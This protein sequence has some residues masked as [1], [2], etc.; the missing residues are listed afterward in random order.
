MEQHREAIFL[1]VE[2]IPGGGEEGAGRVG[3][4]WRGFCGDGPQRGEEGRQLCGLSK[5]TDRLHTLSTAVQGFSE[6]GACP[7]Q[8]QSGE[9]EGED[10]PGQSRRGRDVT[11]VTP[12]EHTGGRGWEGRPL[13][14]CAPGGCWADGWAGS[15]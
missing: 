8:T 15:S 6:A 7:A 3:A 11:G 12:V 2:E 5:Q 4:G 9:G 10:S 14:S 1:G 13:A